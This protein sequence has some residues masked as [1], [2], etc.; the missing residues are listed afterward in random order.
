[1]NEKERH[2]TKRRREHGGKSGRKGKEKE[3]EKKTDV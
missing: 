3:K 1:M 2:M